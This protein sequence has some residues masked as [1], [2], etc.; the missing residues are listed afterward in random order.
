MSNI[1]EKKLSFLDRLPSACRMRDR[2]TAGGRI[3]SQKSKEYKKK[4]KKRKEHFR[5]DWDKDLWD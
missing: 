5:K 4:T 2:D 3:T 1:L